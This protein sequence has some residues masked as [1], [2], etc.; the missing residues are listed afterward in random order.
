MA[1]GVS[2]QELAGAPS[3]DTESSRSAL[4]LLLL[5]RQVLVGSGFL[6]VLLIVCIV[7]ARIAGPV[8]LRSGAF[9]PKL[10]VGAAGWAVLGSTSLGQSVLAQLFQ[11]IPNSMLVSLVAATIGTT[12]GALLGLLS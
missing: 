5:N 1:V 12:L 2:V 6:L 10:G 7:G 9:Q 3:V 4:H 8:P 11:A